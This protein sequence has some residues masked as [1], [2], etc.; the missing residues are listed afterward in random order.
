MFVFDQVF[1]YFFGVG[2][3][4]SFLFILIISMNKRAHA[5]DCFEHRGSGQHWHSLNSI[6]MLD[7]TLL[8]V[9]LL[10]LTCG[11]SVSALGTITQCRQ[12]TELQPIL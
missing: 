3:T 4:F 10:P 11:T 7:L 2:H 9:C 1:H 8:S 5:P 12:Q 6:S